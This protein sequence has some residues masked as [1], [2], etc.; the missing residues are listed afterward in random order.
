MSYEI[1]LYENTNMFIYYVYIRIIITYNN[2]VF[3]YR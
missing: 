1:Y 3:Q 2:V